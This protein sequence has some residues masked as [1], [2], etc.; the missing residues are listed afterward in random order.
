MLLDFMYCETSLP[1]SADRACGLYCLADRF[2]MPQLMNAIQSFVE[3]GLNFTRI[4]EFLSFARRHENKEK[5][6]KLVL[7]ANS[8]LCGYLVKHPEDAGQVPPDLLAHILHSRA[9]CIKVLKGENPRNHSGD[10]ELKRSRLLSKVVATCCHEAIHSDSSKQKLSRQVFER[11]I[12][13]K[14]LPAMDS[15]AALKL[16]QVDAAIAREDDTGTHIEG[17]PG[18]STAAIT[19]AVKKLTYFE[20]R[21]LQALVATW[22][23]TMNGKD[24]DLVESLQR[25]APHILS[26]LLVMVSRQYEGKLAQNKRMTNRNH[27]I[28]DPSFPRKV[29]PRRSD[30]TKKNP[31]YYECLQPST[32]QGVECCTQLEDMIHLYGEEYDED[33]DFTNTSL[34]QRSTY[35][36]TRR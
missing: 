8:K 9:Q 25:V 24:N 16:L 7:F 17:D 6:E 34:V 27:Q 36:S 22:T 11:L 12:N 5:V 30:E 18:D 26:E 20:E 19:K 1:L 33:D 32:T 21:C 29:P 4:I 10:W 23:T 15:D 31:P 2:E 13:P 14:H 28:L 35:A 3:K